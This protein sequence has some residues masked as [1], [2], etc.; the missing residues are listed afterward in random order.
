M[1]DSMSHLTGRATALVAIVVGAASLALTAGPAGAAKTTTL[2]FF[3]K[4]TSASFVGP[5]GA[6]LP[7]PGPTT[8]SVVG[9]KFTSTDD[10]YVGNH[11]HHAK[12][13][14]ASDHLVCTF[15]STQ[16]AATCNGQIAVGGSM[17]LAQD[18]TVDFGPSVSV[19]LNGGT[20]AYKGA[21]GTASAAA[22]DNSSNSDFTIRFTT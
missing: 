13:S 7:P 14:T 20:G 4:G 1:G 10:D 17:L 8:A 18:V 2:H 21:H 6:A 22:F 12:K 5:D 9:E 11:K 3:Q 16:Y 19:P 15:T